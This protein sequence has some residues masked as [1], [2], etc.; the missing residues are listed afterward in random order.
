MRQK[1][2]SFY[3]AEVKLKIKRLIKMFNWWLALIYLTSMLSFLLIFLI[4][5][6]ALA[7]GLLIGNGV[8]AGFTAAPY[9]GTPKKKIR[10]ALSLASLK[11]GEHFYD[12]GSG[13]G[14]SLIIAAREHQA[15][16][17]GFELWYFLYL[18]SKV[19]IF[20]HSCSDK[21]RVY[22]KNFYQTDISNADVI[23]CFLTPK[24]YRRLKD[25]FNKELKNGTRIVTFSSPLG[26]WK[27]QQII[28]FSDK[29]KLFFYI[30][31][32]K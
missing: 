11:P 25:K 16:A 28:T 24:A 12:L 18:W 26:F 7:G 6:T 27:P 8:Y 10:R 30:K 22:W 23:F 13:D 14:R 31:N 20:L 19:S 2:F 15:R 17:T 3:S 21:A 5:L 32:D 9:L 29:S 1:S 4:S